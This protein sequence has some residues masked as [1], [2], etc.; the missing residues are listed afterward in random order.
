MAKQIRATLKD[1]ME[2]A[3]ILEG[4]IESVEGLEGRCIYKEGFNDTV[5]T[6]QAIK[7]TGSKY[8]NN[9]H[10]RYVR[11]ELY[12]DVVT[13]GIKRGAKASQADMET[14]QKRVHD[15]EL[16]YNLLLLK[17]HTD[18]NIDLRHLAVNEENT[19]QGEL[20]S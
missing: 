12:S 18:H 3:R 15:M 17:L 2:I 11:T 5:V 8:L 10:V 7:E 6:R 20:L 4:S 1:R 16:R 19:A 9:N 13:T 14:L